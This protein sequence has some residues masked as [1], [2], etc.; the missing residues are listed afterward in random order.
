MTDHGIHCVEYS[1]EGPWLLLLHGVTRNRRDWEVVL[2]KLTKQWRVVAIDHSG[3]GQSRWTTDGYRVVDYAQATTEFVQERFNEPITVLGHSLGAMVALW[4]AAKC[5]SLVSRAILEDPPF[6]TMG[7]GIADTSYL[8]LFTGMQSV[9]RQ[10]GDVDRMA[11]A[12]AEIRLPTPEGTVSLGEVRDRQS[13]RFSAECIRELDPDIFSPLIA[14]QWLDD[15]DHE[16]LWSQATCPVLLLQGDATAGGT[17]TDADL[18][19]AKKQLTNFKCVS[20]NGVGHQIHSKC[21]ERFLKELEG[22][23]R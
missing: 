8:A 14:S 21:P 15:F 12:L 1:S 9:A 10:R 22:F 3:H 4:L 6:H 20:F 5:P 19:I 13:L 7:N 23:V 2:P 17:L 16:S 11:N 18:A